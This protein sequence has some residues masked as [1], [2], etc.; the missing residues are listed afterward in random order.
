MPRHGFAFCKLI[1]T[2][3][4]IDLVDKTSNSEIGLQFGNQ[5]TVFADTP[6]LEFRSLTRDVFS[7]RYT[8]ARIPGAFLEDAFFFVAS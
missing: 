2:L 3:S 7:R 6:F 1:S 8:T 4:G 5:F